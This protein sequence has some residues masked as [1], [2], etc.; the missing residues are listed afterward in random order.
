[1]QKIANGH[2]IASCPKSVT[3][4][5]TVK[6]SGAEVASLSAHKYAYIYQFNMS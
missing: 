6:L 3:G 2:R 4:W 5:P 1:V